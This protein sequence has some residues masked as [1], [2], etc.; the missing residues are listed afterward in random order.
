VH[1]AHVSCHGGPDPA[2]PWST[3][4]HLKPGQTLDAQGVLARKT[5]PGELIAAAC[6]AMTTRE[7]PDGDP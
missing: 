5:Q 1:R 4:L 3:V 6:V 2:Y 7:D